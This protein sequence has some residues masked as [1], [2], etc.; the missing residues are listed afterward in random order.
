MGSF[1]PVF[2]GALAGGSQNPLG[3]APGA[4]QPGQVEHAA[5]NQGSGIAQ[6]MSAQGAA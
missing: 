6:A 2:A 1:E 5:A 4:A 3:A